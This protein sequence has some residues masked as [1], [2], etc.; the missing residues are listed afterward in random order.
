MFMPSPTDPTASNSAPL[1]RRLAALLY[2]AFLILAISMVYGALAVLLYVLITGDRG[3]ANTPMF[4][5]PWFPLG[6]VAIIVGF[7]CF[8]W[9][10]GGQTLGMR[11]W[12]IQLQNQEGG[13][14]SIKQCLLRCAVAPISLGL[15]GLGYWWVWVDRRGLSWHD[16]LSRTQVILR[17]KTK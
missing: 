10:R 1:W 14:P 3:E 4:D 17:D 9:R 12:R 2:D 7:Y 6:W 8:F 13:H 5:S 15:A 11:A 16:R